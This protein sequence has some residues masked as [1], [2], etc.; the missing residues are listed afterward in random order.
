MGLS[1]MSMTNANNHGS[2]L[3]RRTTLNI[4]CSQKPLNY[5]IGTHQTTADQLTTPQTA[6]EY[7]QFL[8]LQ[9]PTAFVIYVS[10]L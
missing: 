8:L 2:P 3:A 7:L 4:I 5:C 10:F 9:P 1:V 6:E